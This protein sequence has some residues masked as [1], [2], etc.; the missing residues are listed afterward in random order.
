MSNPNIENIPDYIL[1]DIRR[2]IPFGKKEPFTNEELSIKTKKQLLEHFL[3]WNGIIGYSDTIID[4]V[5]CIFE[6][7]LDQ[8]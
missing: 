3:A 8:E 6:I 2:N 4:A 7:E 5:E 1:E